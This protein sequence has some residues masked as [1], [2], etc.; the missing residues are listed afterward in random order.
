MDTRNVIDEMKGMDEDRIRMVRERRALPFAVLINNVKGS[1]N[2]GVIIRNANFYGAE[3]VFYY[4]DKHWNRVPSVGCY[5]YMSI[6]YISNFND[7][8]KL[9]AFYNFV[10]I[11][12]NTNHSPQ[13]LKRYLP[14]HNNIYVFGS[15]GEGIDPGLIEKCN[16]FVEIRTNTNTVR[17]LNVSVCSGI[18]MNHHVNTVNANFFVKALMRL[19]L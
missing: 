1:L 7:V 11:D 3:K 14:R 9:K 8:L 12:N 18:V 6:E 2:T 10:G 4:G 15:E 17:S 5:K 19:G 13:N 16:D